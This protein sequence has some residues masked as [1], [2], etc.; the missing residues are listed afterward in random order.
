MPHLNEPIEAWKISRQTLL[1][2]SPSFIPFRGFTVVLFFKDSVA[3]IFVVLVMIYVYSLRF[4]LLG[5]FFGSEESG[6]MGLGSLFL[7]WEGFLEICVNPSTRNMIQ[8]PV[9]V[10][11]SSLRECRKGKVCEVGLGCGF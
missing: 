10:R 4:V 1:C 8:Y 7:V 9:L 5:L 2:I 6:N 3:G 11:Y